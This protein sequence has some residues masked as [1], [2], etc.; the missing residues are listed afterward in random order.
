MPPTAGTAFAA[1]VAFH[2]FA[3][4][5]HH[6]VVQFADGRELEVAT[7]GAATRRSRAARARS[8]SGRRK[9]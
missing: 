7:P 5:A 2:A 1:T 4:Q 8:S 3:G 6:Y 9:T